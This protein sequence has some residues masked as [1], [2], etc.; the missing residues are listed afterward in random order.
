MNFFMKLGRNVWVDVFK[1]GS[2]GVKVEFFLDRIFNK[3]MIVF[4]KVYID[5]II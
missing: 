2:F 5:V 3:G 1:I 4:R